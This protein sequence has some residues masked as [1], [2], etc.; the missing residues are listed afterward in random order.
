MTDGNAAVPEG[1]INGDGDKCQLVREMCTKLMSGM[2]DVQDVQDAGTG[3]DTYCHHCMIILT[4]TGI[5]NH[6]KIDTGS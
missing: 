6:L 3:Y 5:R 4:M 1:R 2:Q